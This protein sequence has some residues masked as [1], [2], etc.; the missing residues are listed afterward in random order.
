MRRDGGV[1]QPTPSGAIGRL[2]QSI[3]PAAAAEACAGAQPS[4]PPL[5][6]HP[7]RRGPISRHRR[8]LFGQ[9]SRG[10]PARDRPPAT[11]WPSGRLEQPPTIGASRPSPALGTPAV[12]NGGRGGRGWATRDCASA[13][14]LGGRDLALTVC[15]RRRADSPDRA[16]D[17][18]PLSAA[19]RFHGDRGIAHLRY[20]FSRGRC[21][22]RWPESGGGR[23]AARRLL[24]AHSATQS[25]RDFRASILPRVA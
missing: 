15:G 14:D 11:P 16:R 20:G 10:S 22:G 19:W 25:G 7:H 6:G 12:R 1:Q 3:V 13:D 4:T 24:P 17:R 2:S 8:R 23:I 5:C 21:R 9:S 18:M